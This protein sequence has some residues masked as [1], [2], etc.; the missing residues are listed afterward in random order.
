VASFHF[1]PNQWCVNNLAQVAGEKINTEQNTLIETFWTAMAETSHNPLIKNLKKTKKKYFV[2]VAHRQ[3]HVIFNK[4]G[5]QKIL[6]YIL[7]HVSQEFLCVFVVHDL[8]TG[9]VTS[10]TSKLNTEQKQKIVQTK[11]LSYSDYMHVIS[12]SEFMIT[13]GGSN[14]EEMY[15]MGKPCLILRNYSERIEGLEENALLSKNSEQKISYFLD[16]Y[17]DFI[18]K[19]IK[20]KKKPS[21]IIVNYLWKKADQN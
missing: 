2:L 21:E 6:E 1:C 10:L 12:G 3:E 17:K 11:R 9:F 8:S 13:D 19:P 7:N 18:R 16:H 5:T 14:Q 20:P 15:Y 4:K